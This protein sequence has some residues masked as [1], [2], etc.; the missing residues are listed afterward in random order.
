MFL[1]YYRL[2]CAGTVRCK[3]LYFKKGNVY[4]L[5]YIFKYMTI[6][7]KMWSIHMQIIILCFQ[8]LIGYLIF[9]N[10]FHP[11]QQIKCNAFVL[12]FLG[13]I[14]LFYFLVRTVFGGKIKQILWGANQ[15]P[16]D[17]H[18]HFASADAA[19]S[20]VSR[21]LPE[22]P[23]EFHWQQPRQLHWMCSWRL[24]LLNREMHTFSCLRSSGSE[25]FWPHDSFIM[26]Q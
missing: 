8:V 1:L 16:P 20:I 9:L 3:G 24:S 18:K 23:V 2:K 13:D 19:N 22:W 25:A 17:P 5:D 4:F 26:W 14:F 15:L 10:V 6:W 11:Y 7:V 12:A 21:P